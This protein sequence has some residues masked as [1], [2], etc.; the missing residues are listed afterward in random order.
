MTYTGQGT[1]KNGV[2]AKD[3]TIIWSNKA[4]T[5]FKGEREKGLTR[6]PIRVTPLNAQHKLEPAA[7]LNYAK[8]YTIEY[9]AKVC[10]IGEVHLDSQ[11]QFASDYYYV[12]T[13]IEIREAPTDG[14]HGDPANK[15][16]S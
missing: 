16:S 10:F 12:H 5:M 4:P 1:L 6:T 15:S 3:H 13:P 7:R 8:V 14:H 9:N 2:N 11:Y